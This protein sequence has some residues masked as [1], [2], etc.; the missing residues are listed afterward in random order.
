MVYRQQSGVTGFCCSIKNL[1]E[2]IIFLEEDGEEIKERIKMHE[3]DFKDGLAQIV[4]MIY[5]NLEYT[6]PSFI[7][8]IIYLPEYLGDFLEKLEKVIRFSKEM[9]TSKEAWLN[10]IE[11]IFQGG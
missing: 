3:E 7:D 1:F 10:A 6:S 2:L 5:E 8:P 11:E 4:E 9:S